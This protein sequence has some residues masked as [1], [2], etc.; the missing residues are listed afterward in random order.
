MTTIGLQELFALVPI[1]LLGLLFY[2]LVFFCIW[3]FYAMLSKIND[4][5]AGIRR[6]FEQEGT[7]RSVEPV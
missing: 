6:A 4:N 5:M 3:K 2:G 7:R 1:A